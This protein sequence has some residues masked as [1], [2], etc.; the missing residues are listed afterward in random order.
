MRRLVNADI[1][2]S[3]KAHADMDFDG[4]GNGQWWRY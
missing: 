4:G 1:T 2:K 3:G